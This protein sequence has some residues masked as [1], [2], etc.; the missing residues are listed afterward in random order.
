MQAPA[1][2]SCLANGSPSSSQHDEQTQAGEGT[3][4]LGTA[5][6]KVSSSLLLCLWLFP[7]QEKWPYLCIV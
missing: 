6:T 4:I 5:V 1:V 7:G 3:A 2:L